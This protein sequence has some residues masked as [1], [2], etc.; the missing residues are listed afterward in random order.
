MKIADSA[1][2]TKNIT[3]SILINLSMLFLVVLFCSGFFNDPYTG[4][5]LE[6]T[7]NGNIKSERN[8]KQGRLHGS[9]K[10]YFLNGKTKFEEFY[11]DDQLDGLQ[12][13][14]YSNGQ[15]AL[16]ITYKDGAKLGPCT[17]YFSD[18]KTHIKTYY[19]GK[20][21]EKSAWVT[22]NLREKEKQ[23]WDTFYYH[24]PGIYEDEKGV[25]QD[26]YDV[27]F[28]G[29]YN[30]SKR[31]SENFPLFFPDDYGVSG[32]LTIWLNN[33]QK[34]YETTY[35]DT[36][37]IG[38]KKVWHNNGQLYY[39]IKYDDQGKVLYRSYYTRNG[40]K[41]SE[42]YPYKNN[43]IGHSKYWNKD[44][45]LT[46]ESYIEKDVF[47]EVYYYEKTAI[48][49]L[50]KISY[51]DKTND[52]IKLKEAYYPSGN[53][54]SVTKS[55][56]LK[57]SEKEN[58]DTLIERNNN[59]VYIS[60]KNV[61]CEKR[62][63]KGY[64]EKGNIIAEFN[65]MSIG[66]DAPVKGVWTFYP[67][68][69]QKVLVDLNN[70]EINHFADDQLVSKFEIKGYYSYLYGWDFSLDGIARKFTGDNALAVEVP[71]K[72][73]EPQGPA[74][75]I[76]KEGQYLSLNLK[77]DTNTKSFPGLPKERESTLR[78]FNLVYDFVKE[79]RGKF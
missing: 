77:F 75:F 24:I 14:Y 2:N 7:A 3:K 48:R 6:L 43:P 22:G 26:C 41:T 29:P 30:L 73:G 10:S 64:D 67:T 79:T 20:I 57:T 34:E 52:L 46:D 61:S 72:N 8:Y 38:N 59:D 39:H 68:E 19:N 42:T 23:C 58:V 71:F 44:G 40:I 66:T 9:Q 13:Y 12:K 62:I 36:I 16:E 49:K 5:T 25:T 11:K 28:D 45:V 60:T 31:Y 37:I 54:K 74:K 78:Y 56:K 35:K 27:I 50:K 69:N 47:K 4:G 17:W 76:N 51:F 1:L 55:Y 63:T 65:E 21:N 15:L 32:N 18:G 33:G 70:N 53:V